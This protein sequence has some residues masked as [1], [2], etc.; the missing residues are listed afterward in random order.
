M[1]KMLQN[2]TPVQTFCHFFDKTDS[3][4][5]NKDPTENNR[6]F[7]QNTQELICLVVC[8]CVFGFTSIVV[9][10]MKVRI[11]NINKIFRKK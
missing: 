9:I 5:A 8:I 1:S 11:E 6:M 10:Y 3:N 2:V 7:K 4:Q